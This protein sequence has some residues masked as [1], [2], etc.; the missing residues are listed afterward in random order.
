MW[1]DELDRWVTECPLCRARFEGWKET[2]AAYNLKVHM[3]NFHISPDE[4][5]KWKDEM[6]EW[7]IVE[8]GSDDL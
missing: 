3:Q 7:D 5:E 8:W 6:V 4:F 1:K 2:I